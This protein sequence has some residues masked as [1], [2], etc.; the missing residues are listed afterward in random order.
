MVEKS[1]AGIPRD[2]MNSEPK[3]HFHLQLSN[4]ICKTK[5]LPL[6]LTRASIIPQR[7]ILAA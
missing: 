1:V 5:L 6:T 2:V 7:S 3:T 4:L